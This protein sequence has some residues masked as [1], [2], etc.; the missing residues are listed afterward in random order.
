[1]HANRRTFHCLLA[2]IPAVVASCT[3]ESPTAWRVL[4]EPSAHADILFSEWSEAVNVGPP[5]NSAFNDFIPELSGNGLSLYFTS[6]RPGGLGAGDL[7]V[8][9]RA[10]SDAPWGEP[11]NLGATINTSGGESAPHLSGDGH[12]LFFASTRSGGFGNNDIWVSWR[13]HTDDDF[14]WQ[15]PVNLGANVNSAAFDAGA[16]LLRPEFY[17]TSMRESAPNLDIYVSE[18]AGDFFGP[19]IRVAELSSAAN[20]QRPSIRFDGLE[21]F[22]SS[23]RGS[24]DGSQ[25]IWVA[26]RRNRSAPWNAPVLLGPEINT[27]FNDQ[28][29]AIAA[30][31][32]TL[33]FASTRPGGRGGGDIY[34]ATRR[35]GR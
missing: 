33:L 17:F 23:N 27:A 8:S 6:D 22:F 7:W 9:Q 14:A 31:G 34:I 20:D 19:A 30:D 13:A 3:A 12:Y 2:I 4:A 11:V 32:T 10:S 21:I 35:V 28:Q 26:T 5:V 29:P 25:N 16:S 15:P 1:M 18:V 24:A